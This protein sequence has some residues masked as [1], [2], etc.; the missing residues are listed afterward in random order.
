MQFGSCRRCWTLAAMLV[1]AAAATTQ[2]VDAQQADKD[3]QITRVLWRDPGPVAARDLSWKSD[4]T[5]RPPAAP[6]TFVEEDTSGTRIKLAVKDADGVSW[7]VKLADGPDA[8]GEVHAEVAAARLTW[9]L[10]YFVEESYYV[11][12]GVIEGATKLGRA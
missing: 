6:F 9:A 7:N 2:L 3:G 11:A 12:D 10:G 8:P 5:R 1:T 4:L